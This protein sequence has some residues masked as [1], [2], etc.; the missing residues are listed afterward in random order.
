MDA[1]PC[2]PVWVTL[3]W[4]CWGPN[5]LNVVRQL[6]QRSCCGTARV[7]CCHQL[8]CCL[9]PFVSPAQMNCCRPGGIHYTLGRA[10]R[11]ARLAVVGASAP[12]S[13]RTS[14]CASAAQLGATL[15]HS[16]SSWLHRRLP[17]LPAGSLQT[18]AGWWKHL[19]ANLL[20]RF[21][22]ASICG[23]VHPAASSTAAQR[24]APTAAA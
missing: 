20:R 17:P 8:C 15:Q 4:R 1:R 13:P 7:P 9:G 19:P 11:S 14:F 22:A 16:P 18:C 5:M 3:T 24:C 6:G 10:A 12:A 23:T 21:C 2:R